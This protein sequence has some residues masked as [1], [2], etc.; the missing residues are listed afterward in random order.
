MLKSSFN[1]VATQ[2]DDFETQLLAAATVH[3]VFKLEK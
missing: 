2:I 3:S 1:K